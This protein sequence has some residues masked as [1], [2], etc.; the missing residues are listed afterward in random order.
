MKLL[1]GLVIFTFIPMI[2]YAAEGGDIAPHMIWRIIDFVIF[3]AILY[4][5]LKNP[6]VT[7]FKTR[8]EEI[9]NSLKE[10]EKLKA[11]A[12]LLLEETEKKLSKLDMEI[13]KIVNTFKSIAEHEKESIIKET[14]SIIERIR[15]STEEEKIALVNKA[16]FELL[17]IITKE[18]IE[19]LRD[20]LSKLA[21]DKH[22][23]INKKFIGSITR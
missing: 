13:E 20:K 14:Q 1:I 7:Y 10:A 2:A 12:E 4:Y 21:I 23:K 16:K 19:M 6:I 3:V 5:F 17:K 18:S 9:K 11:E 15:E 8:K 22:I